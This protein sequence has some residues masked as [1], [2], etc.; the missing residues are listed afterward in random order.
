MRLSAIMPVPP[1]FWGREFGTSALPKSVRVVFEVEGQPAD[2]VVAQCVIAT[3]EEGD[4]RMSGLWGVANN[5]LRRHTVFGWYKVDDGTILLQLHPPD[6]DDPDQEEGP[7][8]ADEE[9]EDEAVR[10][11]AGA[12]LQ[13]R[14]LQRGPPPGIPELRVRGRAGCCTGAVAAGGLQLADRQHMLLGQTT[15]KPCVLLSGVHWGSRWC[16]LCPRSTGLDGLT[17]SHTTPL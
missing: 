6:S 13:V 12:L 8:A 1:R 7:A 3:G 2:G 15:S 4:L 14:S 10:L 11:A 16:V 5:L 9:D 17:A